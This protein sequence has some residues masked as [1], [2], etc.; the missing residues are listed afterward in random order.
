MLNSKID[1]RHSSI[2]GRGLVARD[3]IFPGE[4]IWLA[5]EDDPAPVFELAEIETWPQSERETFWALAYRVGESTYSGPKDPERADTSDYMNHSCDPTAWFCGYDRMEAR[6]LIEPGEEVTFDYATSGI[7]PGFELH[8][9]CGTAEC[10]QLV[11]EEDVQQS[12]Q[13]R[14]KYAG[15]IL[16]HM[17][18]LQPVSRK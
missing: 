10:R 3:R 9:R 18:V 4:M 12:K 17:L 2:A 11:T 6:R 7:R 15:H 14:A 13:L 1:V 16:E 8:C 5:G